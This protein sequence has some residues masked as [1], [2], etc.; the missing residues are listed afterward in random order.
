M[1]IRL[2]VMLLFLLAVISVYADKLMPDFTLQDVNGNDV[3]LENALKNGPVIVDFWA[4]WCQP[5]LKELPSLNEFQKK[6]PNITVLAI[7]IDAPKST[8]RAKSEVK[9]KQYEFTTLFDTNQTVKG[10]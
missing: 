5:C 4:S 1:K 9:S 6:Y 2:L 7:T 10:K 3:N 8:A